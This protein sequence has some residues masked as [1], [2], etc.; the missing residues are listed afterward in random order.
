MLYRI[1]IQQGNVVTEEMV[2]KLKSGMTRSQVRFVLGSPLITD[3]FHHDRWDYIYRFAPGGRIAEEKRLTV[4]FENDRLTGIDGD[5]PLP[6][7]FSES[8]QIIPSSSQSFDSIENRNN[9][10]PQEADNGQT[11][12]FLKQNQDDFYRGR[13]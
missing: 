9:L 12:D 5:F 6:A 10:L 11:I 2:N 8:E 3:A 4:F 7:S 1:D 13:E